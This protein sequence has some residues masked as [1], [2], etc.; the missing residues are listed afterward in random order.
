ML[1]VHNADR[2]LASAIA[3]LEK[4]KAID[5]DSMQLIRDFVNAKKAEGIGKLRQIKFYQYLKTLAIRLGKPL[6]EATSDDLILFVN[7]LQDEKYSQNT[8]HDVKI[9]M[10]QFYNWLNNCE[11]GQVAPVVAKIS[12]G[13]IVVKHV[14]ESE[15][16]T[17]EQMKT[18]MAATPDARNKALIGLLWGSALR[19]EELLNL[20]VK[21]FYFDEVSG[22]RHVKVMDGKTPAAN[23][24]IPIIDEFVVEAV[25]AWLE[26]HPK[27]GEPGF[28]EVLLFFPK[29]GK[30]VMSGANALKI[31][32]GSCHRAGLPDSTLYMLRRSR[33]TLW[34][35]NPAIT[36]TQ[37][38]FLAGHEVGSGA[39]NSYTKKRR[40][41]LSET[42]RK[43]RNAKGGW[44]KAL[45]EAAYALF[46][47]GMES[48]SV[49]AEFFQATKGTAEFDRF[50]EV[51][52]IGGKTRS[53]RRETVFTT[54]KATSPKLEQ[55][56]VTGK[57]KQKP[58]RSP[59]QRSNVK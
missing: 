43:I 46:R 57:I 33:L 19:P 44:E 12:A 21:H 51:M 58:K 11:K 25:S 37:L 4:E 49:A 2:T 10:R 17:E 52:E 41:Q 6:K 18:I 32:K 24:D 39:L 31:M 53:P 20:R 22:L 3:N 8:C 7:R 27:N 38:Y 59:G 5:M 36:E 23:R 26:V 54:N 9:I 15:I 1:D 34:S 45:G 35:E 28:E 42:F 40:G 30:E 56:N 16:I 48:D 14:E 13:K 29:Y 50:F 47:K 55:I